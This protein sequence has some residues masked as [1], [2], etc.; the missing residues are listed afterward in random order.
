MLRVNGG[1]SDRELR[2]SL[3]HLHSIQDVI[4]AEYVKYALIKHAAHNKV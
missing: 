4:Y 2:D 3:L 1:M